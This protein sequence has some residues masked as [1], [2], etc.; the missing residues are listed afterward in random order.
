[1]LETPETIR[2]RVKAAV[3]RAELESMMMELINIPSPTGNEG[4]LGHYLAGRFAS[5]GMKVEFQEIEA[6]RNNIICKLGEQTPVSTVMFNGTWT[7]AFQEVRSEPGKRVI[8]Y[9]DLGLRI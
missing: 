8:G 4:E 9:L 2:S 6:G 7:P 5:L 3:D 1:M